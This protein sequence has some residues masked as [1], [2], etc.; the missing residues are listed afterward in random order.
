MAG[1][2][3]SAVELFPLITLE[4][5]KVERLQLH[6]LGYSPVPVKTGDKGPHITG[7]QKLSVATPDDIKS[8]SKRHT[9]HGNTGILTERTPVLDIDLLNKDAGDAV[10]QLIRDRFGDYGT[11]LVRV[12][13]SPKR[14]IPF[15]TAK[16][17]DKL[18]VSLINANGVN[19]DKI[20]LLCD[21]QQLVAHGIHKDTGRPY[22]W[23]G[24][25]LHDVERYALPHLNE[26]EARLLV[27][28]IVELLTVEYGYSVTSA[29]KKAESNFNG[30]SAEWGGLVKSIIAGDALHDNTLSLAAKLV[31]SG[32]G[33]GAAVNFLRDLMDSSAAARDERWQARYNDIPRI[34][35]SAGTKYQQQSERKFSLRK[36]SDVKSDPNEIAHFIK[37]LI[38][39]SGITVVWGEPK[40]GKTFQLIDMTMHIARAI[41]YRGRKTQ[42]GCIV[43]IVLEGKKGFEKRIEAYRQFHRITEEV[44]F[45]TIATGLDLIREHEALISDIKTELGPICPGVIVV[46]TLN[47]S[48]AGSENKPEDMGAYLSAAENVSRAFDDCAV[49]IAHH[50]GVEGTRP[51]GHSSLGGTVECQISVKKTESDLVIATVELAKD[52]EDGTEIVSKM[53][54]V[55]LVP[56]REG[57]PRTSCVLVE[58]NA[59]VKATDPKLSANQKTMLSILLDAGRS[60]LTTTEWNDKAKDL[61]IGGKRGH[62]AWYDIRRSLLKKNIIRQS[63]DRWSVD[64]TSEVTP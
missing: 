45:Y 18:Q 34:V 60:G 56:D 4:Q 17:F 12:G 6:A 44:P 36:F 7:W 42:Q 23:I 26:A 9:D 47:R 10:E 33:G 22:A 39:R 3:I 11:V 5:A 1:L 24:A 57:T 64:H 59:P 46:D 31:R 41:E 35:D 38:P 37:D 40:C 50:C 27:Q 63:G 48:L 14:A 53:E 52:M 16:P 58:T 21:G 43:Y 32:M 25:Q 62:A 2:F 54:E 28:D 8:W 19:G 51:R 15:Q 13:K 49:L 29:A 55:Q 61:Q 20:E 30:Q